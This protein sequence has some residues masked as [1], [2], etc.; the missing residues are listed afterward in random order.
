MT[1]LLVRDPIPT[2]DNGKCSG[3]DDGSSGRVD[4]DAHADDPYAKTDDLDSLVPVGVSKK[5]TDD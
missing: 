2:R 1:V 5:S 3:T 4:D